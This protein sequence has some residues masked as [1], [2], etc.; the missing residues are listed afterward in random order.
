VS[1][2]LHEPVQHALLAGLVE[3]DGELVALD[4]D[5]V[6]VAEFQMKDAVADREI[7]GVSATDL[8]TGLPSIRRP[9]TG[10]RPAPSPE[11]ASP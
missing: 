10:L 2:P 11:S 9:F 7:R 3:I 8:A 4:G 5:D 6:A 1:N